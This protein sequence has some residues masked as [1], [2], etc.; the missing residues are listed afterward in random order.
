VHPRTQVLL[1]FCTVFIIKWICD[2]KSRRPENAPRKP[3]GGYAAPPIEGADLL[4]V[5]A[6]MARFQNH[7]MLWR[8]TMLLTVLFYF[9]NSIF[10]TP[11][12]T[13]HRNIIK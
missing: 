13:I 9:E 1:D 7:F 10:L 3:D 12:I 11:N 8:L 2:K 6:T 5:T 4:H